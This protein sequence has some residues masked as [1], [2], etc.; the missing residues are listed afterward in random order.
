[1]AIYPGQVLSGAPMYGCQVREISREL[2]RAQHQSLG[3]AVALMTGPGGDD[4]PGLGRN[5]AE[6]ACATAKPAAC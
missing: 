4:G 2:E 6:P 5:R 3:L 1:M